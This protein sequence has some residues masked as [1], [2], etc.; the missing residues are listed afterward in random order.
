MNPSGPGGFGHQGIS[1]IPFIHLPCMPPKTQRCDTDQTP[2][3][4][5]PEDPKKQR[6][7]QR[8]GTTMIANRLFQYLLPS[9]P[10]HHAQHGRLPSTTT[11]STWCPTWCS[12]EGS[13][14]FH[15]LCRDLDTLAAVLAQG[16]NSVIADFSDLARLADAVS[17]AHERGAEITL[18]TPRMQKPGEAQIFAR[19]AAQRPDGMLVRN[20][21]GT[22]FCREQNL[23]FVADASFHA[24]NPWTVAQ[25]LELGARRVTAAYDLDGDRL[26]ELVAAV[27]T[28]RLEMIVYQHLPLFHTEHCLYT[29]A[30]VPGANRV[31]C[32]EICRR[33][34]VRLR[35]RRGVEHPLWSDAA[36]RNTVFHAEPQNRLATVPEFRRR[37]VRH[38]RVE[39]L[40][41]KAWQT[42]RLSDLRV[43]ST[44]Y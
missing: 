17:L 35:D 2:P 27:P 39:L 24:V 40:S 7:M 29:W 3:T 9:P 1:Q 23:P 10:G 31:R 28:E 25:L 20:L 22:A 5:I 34:N 43:L 33:H 12:G 6:T 38:F 19:L 14:D 26:E 21:A 11:T 15:I 18:A 37:G 4:Q 13:S 30:L 16:A 36:C 32:G 44:E 41:G 8:K 42:L